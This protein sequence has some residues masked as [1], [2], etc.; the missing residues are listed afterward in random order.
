M[1]NR[2]VRPAAATF[3][4]Y[5]A[6]LLANLAVSIVVARVLGRQGA[7]IIVLALVV[8][9]VI[10]VLAN[11]GLPR[12]LA[13]LIRTG[14]LP[15]GRATLLALV[16]AEFVALLAAAGYLLLWPQLS[17][18]LGAGAALDQL[19]PLAAAILVLEVALQVLM[20]ACQGFEHFGRRSAILLSFRWLYAALAIAALLWA[21]SLFDFEPSPAVVLAASVAAYALATIIGIVLVWQLVSRAQPVAAGPS[22]WQSLKRMVGF[23]WRAHIM[24]VLMLLVL[25]ADVFLLGLLTGDEAQVGLYS[26]AAQVA[27]VIL[28][29]MLAMESVIYVRVGALGR[30]E[31]PLAAADMSRVGLLAGAGLVIVFALASWW[32]IVVPFGME[33]AA[34]V[35][36]LR[37]LL[38]G[39]LAIGFGHMIMAI[40][41]AIERPWPPAVVTA[42]GLAL[43]TALDFLLI[44]AWG[45]VGAAWA[46]LVAYTVMA[47]WAAVWLSRSQGIGLRRLMLPRA[48]DFRL[49]CQLVP[50]WRRPSAEAEGEWPPTEG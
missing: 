16:S 42:G 2:F 5:L 49:L 45:I 13:Q 8:P 19:A 30:K 12:A 38:P 26:R 27:E 11:L 41:Q 4:A 22:A 46:S 21:G 20:A 10:A 28:Y 24:A 14:E 15:A 43:V 32:L 17:P 9:N 7:G 37:I 48:A 47:V 50:L 3:A 31:G 33:F 25:R 34:S 44:P 40:F 23:G 1:R 39:V 35:V 6:G 36:P 18:L 29:L